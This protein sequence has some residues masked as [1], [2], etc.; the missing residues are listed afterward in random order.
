MQIGRM[1]AWA[2]VVGLASYDRPSLG[3]Q[4]LG[5]LAIPDSID[6]VAGPH[7]AVN[8]IHRFF[9]GREY[10]GL[11]T[12]PLRVELLD[13]AVEGEGL[14]PV[15]AGGGAQTKSLWLRGADGYLYGFRSVDK[16]PGDVLPPDLRE[17][18]VEDIV[19][20]QTS[21][22]HPAA[23]AVVAVLL[24]A[25]GIAHTDPRLVVMPDDPRLAEHRERFAGTLG[26]FERRATIEPGVEPFGGAL[27]IIDSDELFAR[28]TESPLDRV[29]LIT[30]LEAR[31]FDYVIGDWDRHRGQWN[32][33]RLDTD[34]VTHWVP[35]PEDR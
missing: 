28:A 6:V 10:R 24:E 18:F 29:D 5:P 4:E 22:Q 32:W 1:A 19:K 2:L 12:T 8:G 23:P 31:L 26:F 17:T 9:L 7:Y 13:L 25:A 14:T 20:D 35:L 11:W 15:S 34:S 27:E 30:Y 3:A 33:M 16:D 21:S